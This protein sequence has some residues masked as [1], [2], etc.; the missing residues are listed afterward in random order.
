MKELS[1]HIK[2]EIKVHA[3]KQEERQRKF[4]GSFIKHKGQTVWEVDL[5][6]QEIKPAEFTEEFA[7]IN[8]GVKRNI[9][10]KEFHWYCVAINKKNAERKFNKMAEIVINQIHR[11]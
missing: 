6:T 5:K 2:E 3:Q 1:S 11:P 10:K 9:I 8:G 7:T 4:I